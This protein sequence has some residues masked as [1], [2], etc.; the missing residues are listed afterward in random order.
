M[1]LLRLVS[2]NSPT[3]EQVGHH[4][5]EQIYGGEMEKKE[6]PSNACF[7]ERGRAKEAKVVRNWPM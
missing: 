2:W 5:H 4:Y 3:G 6:K 1:V 7:V